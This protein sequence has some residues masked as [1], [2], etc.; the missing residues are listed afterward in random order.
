MPPLL[1]MLHWVK[2]CTK[3]KTLILPPLEPGRKLPFEITDAYHKENPHS[4]SE[5]PAVPASAS[6]LIEE[7]EGSQS[8]LAHTSSH[9]VS[10]PSAATLKGSATDMEGGQVEGEE[11]GQ[12]EKAS[13]LEVGELESTPLAAA[14][15]RYMGIDLSPEAKLAELR[16][17]AAVVMF[18]PPQSGCSTQAGMLA[19]GYTAALLHVDTVI[20]ESIALARTPAGQKARKVCIEATLARQKACEEEAA[21]SALSINQEQGKKHSSKDKDK[22]K[23]KEGDRSLEQ[24][25]P[26]PP[27]MDMTPFSVKVEEGSEWEVPKGSLL[28]TK[29]PENIVVDILAE[30]TLVSQPQH[31]VGP[32]H[33]LV[34]VEALCILCVRVCPCVRH[35]YLCTAPPAATRLLPQC[36]GGR[37]ALP[38]HSPPHA[39]YSLGA[40][41]T[42]R[43]K[44]H[45]LCQPVLHL[46][47]PPST[48]RGTGEGRGEKERFVCKHLYRP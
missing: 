6:A 31:T 22:E 17:G 46:R 15:A 45:L 13:Q 32:W 36:G 43:Q 1:Q 40:E 35:T 28:P 10:K 38:V 20:K 34:R 12:S 27:P 19:E 41:G 2:S 23:E 14:I 37:P 24:D 21:A 5:Q 18:G 9:C 4:H 33:T 48:A 30:R 47:G 7:E 26:Q 29:L 25:V 42:R 44:T 3:Q 39:G 16:R 11:K 8:S